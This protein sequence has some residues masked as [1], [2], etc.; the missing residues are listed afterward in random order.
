MPGARGRRDGFGQR[1]LALPPE[2]IFKGV[3]LSQ[4]I[5]RAERR[6]T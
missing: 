4:P 2:Y 3:M 6:A 5:E 1:N